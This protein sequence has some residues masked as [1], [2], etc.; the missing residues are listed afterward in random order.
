MVEAI[1]AG[2]ALEKVQDSDEG[3]IKEVVEKAVDRVAKEILDDIVKD[4]S[5]ADQKLLDGQ[6]DKSGITKR[7]Q[8][9]KDPYRTLSH[10]MDHQAAKKFTKEEKNKLLADKERLE[11]E[12]EKYSKDLK[13]V[14]RSER[15]KFLADK[16]RWEANLSSVEKKLSGDI[17]PWFDMT[18]DT[19]EKT[20]TAWRIDPDTGLMHVQN[21][22]R[23]GKEI[24]QGRWTVSSSSGSKLK[25]GAVLATSDIEVLG[26]PVIKIE[27]EGAKRG[28][29][30]TE[31][32]Y[33]PLTD[34][35]LRSDA[36][37]SAKGKLYD[38]L[39]SG[40]LGDAIRK[41]NESLEGG[42]TRYKLTAPPQ[43]ESLLMGIRSGEPQAQTNLAIRY[44]DLADGE[45]GV[46]GKVVSDDTNNAKKDYKAVHKASIKV[47]TELV[48]KNFPKEVATEKQQATLK[49]LLTHALL[50]NGMISLRGINK[51]STFGS[52]A[53]REQKAFAARYKG[54][55][56]LSKAPTIPNAKKGNSEDEFTSLKYRFNLLIKA[57]PE[58]AVMGI[59]TQQEVKL[60]QD[61]L[62]QKENQKTFIEEAA[63]VSSSRQATSV[64]ALQQGVLL[65]IESLL[66]VSEKRLEGGVKQLRKAKAKGS[67]SEAEVKA[68]SLLDGTEIYHTH[69]RPTNRIPIMIDS[70]GDHH[71][72]VE[73]RF[74]NSQWN[75]EDPEYDGEL[76]KLKQETL[77]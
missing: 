55:M 37:K 35:E 24:E 39:A 4:L 76:L 58:D 6:E 34:Q 68:T 40:K 25:N 73:S 70:K 60:L 13:S 26:Q 47:A 72:V 31:I 45:R 49:A 36:Y 50:T 12:R 74:P 63:K 59:L 54:V 71:I 38:Q 27:V 77:V 1:Q 41:Y 3:T 65:T 16:E 69:P 51:L 62:K 11:K 46:I 61:W 66:K 2:K 28:T 15:K 19:L 14:S 52:K 20:G 8:N 57:S 53:T 21:P 33:G 5:E 56:G 67:G 23:V 43:Y 48:D 10:W 44:T 29:L 32:I 17:P 7:L 42:E 75:S 18:R 64:S 30:A 22:D 9:T